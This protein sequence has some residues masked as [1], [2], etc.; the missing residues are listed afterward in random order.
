MRPIGFGEGAGEKTGP[1]GGMGE[2]QGKKARDE[3][4]R[5][6]HPVVEDGFGYAQAGFDPVA[7][8]GYKE[9][10]ANACQGADAAPVEPTDST[11][12]PGIGRGEG[13]RE[14]P[15]EDD[16]DQAAA[17][18]GLEEGDGDGVEAFDDGLTGQKADQGAG[19]DG[20]QGRGCGFPAGR[21]SYQP[22]DG[23][24]HREPVEDHANAEGRGCG[25]VRGVVGAGESRAV[26]QG[27][28][29]E[30]GQGQDGYGSVDSEFAALP[31][32][33]GE[34]GADEAQEGDGQAQPAAGL[35]GFG[36]DVS[37]H[38]P[39]DGCGHESF[40]E[41]HD[42]GLPSHGAIQEGAQGEAE[43]AEEEEG[44]KKKG[45]R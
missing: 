25:V 4:G 22:P 27:V 17:D 24:A 10:G 40:Q 44:H 23:E 2:S 14:A 16:V 39:E 26:H 45:K 28:E 29:E 32:A 33:F 18:E 19:A 43:D 37:Q 7:G 8:E 38:K 21:S 1:A 13:F 11:G 5:A 15:V 30:S 6:Q 9:E 12:R 3:E 42:G 35:N 36:Q 20:D 34:L 31:P 41:G